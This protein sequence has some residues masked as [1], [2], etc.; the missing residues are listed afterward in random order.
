MAYSSGGWDKYLTLRYLPIETILTC[1]GKCL[2]SVEARLLVYK[3]NESVYEEDIKVSDSKE[4]D[5]PQAKIEKKTVKPSFAKI[6]FVKSKEQVKSPRKTTVKQDG[7]TSVELYSKGESQI[8]RMTHLSPKR[9]MV[10]KAVLMRSGLV[11]LTT[12]KPVNI[13]QPETTVN[14]ARPMTNV[15]IA[16]PKAV[17]NV[18]KGN[19]VN[20]VK[21]LACWSFE[22]QAEVLEPIF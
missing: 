12:A 4:E 18:V 13:V 3:K 1:I 19:K 15:N 14:S 8:S 11:S 16:R 7:K 20:A 5:V 10:P 21:A 22:T 2:E 6:E 17:L 9:N